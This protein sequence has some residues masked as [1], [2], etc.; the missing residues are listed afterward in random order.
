MFEAVLVF[1]A[2]VIVCAAIGSIFVA[3]RSDIKV[4]YNAWT[5]THRIIEPG[6]IW[7]RPW[8]SV[9]TLRLPYRHEPARPFSAF[10]PDSVYRYDPVLPCQCMTADQ[11]PVAVGISIHYALNL[12]VAVK[13]ATTAD[14]AA[15]LDDM[16]RPQVIQCVNRFA[17]KDL[18][19][20]D[21]LASLARVEWSESGSGLRVR[22][23]HV[24]GIVFDQLMQTI[25]CA[26]SAGLDAAS[27][28][29]NYQHHISAGSSS[30]SIPQQPYDSSSTDRV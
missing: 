7:L 5:D 14:F 28:F 23:V 1:V 15:Q 18:R 12:E 20:G 4:V 6:L 16:V 8:E 22:C 17:R 19:M 26:Q 9:V 27:V 13:H 29:N 10:P 21:V 3:H 30:I 2:I 24:Q 11:V 25:L